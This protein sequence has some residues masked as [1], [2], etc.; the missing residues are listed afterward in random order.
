MPMGNPHSGVTHFQFIFAHI[1]DESIPFYPAWLKLDF[2]PETP[3]ALSLDVSTVRHDP[4][5]GV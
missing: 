1:L 2:V 3:E 4:Q 5:T